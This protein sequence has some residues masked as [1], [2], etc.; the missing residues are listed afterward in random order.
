L[1][2]KG[3]GSIGLDNGRGDD[4]EELLLYFIIIGMITG[5]IVQDLKMNWTCL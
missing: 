5:Y 1:F 4:D 3:L 2:G